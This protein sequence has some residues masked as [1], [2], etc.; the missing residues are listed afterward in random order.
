MRKSYVLG[1]LLFLFSTTIFA[2]SPLPVGYW[3]TVDDV[4]NRVNSIVEIY[5]APDHTLAGRIIKT[6][7][8]PG[9][10][11]LVNCNE[12]SGSLHG[13]PVVG[14]TIL[15]GLR[16]DGENT[17]GDGRIVDPKTGSVYHCFVKTIDNGTKL[18][19][20]GYIVFHWLGRSQTWLHIDHP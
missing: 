5:E 8:K 9:T 17:W 3:K 14:M 7:P 10:E 13:K 19:I 11:P 1:F 16:A 15:T 18:I 20:R 4:N 12:C 2:A 6:F